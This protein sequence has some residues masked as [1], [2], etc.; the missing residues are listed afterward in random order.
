[1]SLEYPEELQ[2]L[3]SHE[4][5]RLEGAIATLGISAFAI[6]QLGDIVFLELPAVGE[7]VAQGETFG[8]VESVKAVESMY[9]PVSGIVLERNEQM[10]DNP[11]NLAADPYTTGWLLKISLAE[12]N[13]LADNIL[14]AEEYRS[15]V[16]GE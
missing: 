6:D 1:M 4:Y 12:D 3:D 5:V 7:A 8:T 10:V 14:S 9:S 2:Y 11:E 13:S 16:A 15:L